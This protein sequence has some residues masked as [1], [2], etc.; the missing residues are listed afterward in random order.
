MET[1]DTT[2]ER[3]LPVEVQAAVGMLALRLQK[4]SADTGMSYY[5]DFAPIDP[6]RPDEYYVEQS[7]IDKS[8]S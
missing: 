7:V 3:E 5:L 2:P 4:A 1:Y 8:G 6:D